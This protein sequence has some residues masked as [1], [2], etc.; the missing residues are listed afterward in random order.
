LTVTSKALSTIVIT[1]LRS[2][3]NTLRA[4]N[5]VI[6]GRK[7]D[8]LDPGATKRFGLPPGEHEISVSMD[9]YKSPPLVLNLSGGETVTLECGEKASL[10]GHGQFSLRG[11]GDFLGSA[12]SPSDYFFVRVVSAD[13]AEDGRPVDAGVKQAAPPSS[14]RVEASAPTI[15]LSYRRDDTEHITGRIRDRLGTRFGDQAIFRDV[16]SIPAG[17]DFIRNVEESIRV[18]RV[19]V[20]IIGPQWVAAVDRQG[21]RRLEQPDDPVRFELETA[22]GLGVPILPVLVK[23]AVMPAR[24]DLPASL[25]TLSSIN[26]VIIPPEPYF[27]EGVK[28]LGI[29]IESLHQPVT[30]AVLSPP[31]SCSACGNRINPGQAFCTRCGQ[32]V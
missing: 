9:F 6:D 4:Y 8:K 14:P 25:A 24:D 16:D 5:V 2:A 18:A 17:I 7:V 30:P 26:A 11:L 27:A 3:L 32:K 21:R 20:A 12:L 28:R 1:R 29:A 13:T 10:G 31:T 23:Q 19:L 22:I 15:F